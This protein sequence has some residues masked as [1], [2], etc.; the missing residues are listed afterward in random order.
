MKASKLAGYFLIHIFQFYQ[1]YL[2]KSDKCDIFVT[3]VLSRFTA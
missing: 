2:V 3:I 1:W